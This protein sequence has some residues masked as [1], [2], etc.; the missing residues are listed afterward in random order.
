MTR[1]ID[2]RQKEVI[3]INNGKMLG[4]VVDVDAELNEGAIKSIVVAQVGK[5][6]KSLGGKNNITIPWSNVK[7]IGEDVILVEIWRWKSPKILGLKKYVKFLKI[8]AF[9]VDIKRTLC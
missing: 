4:F 6:L 3:N 5:V 1:G 7:L 8:F 9:F 2:F